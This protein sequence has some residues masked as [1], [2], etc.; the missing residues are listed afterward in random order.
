[1]RIIGIETVGPGEGDR[2]LEQSLTQ[3]KELCDEIAICLN[4]ADE[5]T[6]EIVKKYTKFYVE[7]NR[8]WGLH[9]YK[10]KRDFLRQYVPNLAPDWIIATDADEIFCESFTRAEAE[11]L[12]S[13]QYDVAYYFWVVELWDKEDTYREDL[14]FE[15]IR[16]FKYLPQITEFKPTPL[17]CGLAPEYFYNWGTHTNMYFKHYGLM[18]K[19]DRQRKIERYEKYDPDGKWLAPS[20]YKTL[21]AK[22]PIVKTFDAEAFVKQL[23]PIKHRDKPLPI[24]TPKKE[25]N[26]YVKNRHGMVV[27]IPERHLEMTL[28]QPG[29]ELI[30]KDPIEFDKSGDNP[31]VGEVK[32]SDGKFVCEQCGYEGDD[33]YQLKRHSKNHG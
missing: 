28:K 23:P 30:T 18:A 24:M 8:E 10:I 4:N 12:A 25:K 6:K 17:H 33:A 29:F 26:Y 11:R 2:M 7:D 22:E 16:F 5:K 27:P 21:A 9:Q 31:M 3:L 13:T 20:W 1:M 14:A 32:S 15:N 19:E